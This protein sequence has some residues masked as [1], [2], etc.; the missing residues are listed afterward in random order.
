MAFRLRSGIWCLK[1]RGLAS[2]EMAEK[3]GDF[4]AKETL[5]AKEGDE[6]EGEDFQGLGEQA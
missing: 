6:D 4:I 2:R 1:F 3:C 5:P